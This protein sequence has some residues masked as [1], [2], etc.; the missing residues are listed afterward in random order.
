MTRNRSGE[1]LF[2]AVDNTDSV[3]VLDTT[4][5]EVIDEIPT[6]APPALRPHGPWLRGA[7]PNNLTLSADERLLLVTNGGTNSVAVVA[8]GQAP[9]QAGQVIGL[10]PTGWYPSA[11]AV[12]KGGDRLFVVNGK[13]VAGPNPRACRDTL[14][15]E[16]EALSTCASANQYVWQLEKAGFLTLPMP[17]PRELVRLTGQVAH[18]SRFMAPQEQR[19][20]SK[21]ME[22]LR[23][24]IEHVVYVIK[25]NRTYDQIHGDLDRGNGDPSL[26]ILSP[27]SPNHQR[28]ARSFVTLDNFYDSGETSN[29]GWNWTTAARATD[30]TEKTSPVNYAGRG[31]TYDWEGSNRGINVGLATVSE[32]QLVNPGLALDEDLLPGTSD[33]A[34]P[35][36]GNGEAGAGYLWDAALRAGLTIRN[37]GVW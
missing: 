19:R 25:E 8:L 11:V 4:V 9:G 22:A 5:S 26:A 17:T 33:V 15:T 1:R 30:F 35:D 36:G 7:N 32:R 6:T 10:I 28:L 31:L 23:A 24:R 29:T 34:A 20:G 16:S 2:V 13:G 12:T 21:T 3:V 14:S 27:F 37:Y 18:N